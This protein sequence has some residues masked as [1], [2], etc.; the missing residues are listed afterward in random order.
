MTFILLGTGLPTAHAEGNEAFF[1]STE[2]VSHTPQE[3][4]DYIAAHPYGKVSA[5]YATEPAYSGGNYDYGS[6]TEDYLQDALN[7]LNVCRFIAGLG[8]VALD[9]QY[10]KT[11]QAGAWLCAADG[12]LAHSHSQPEGVPDD[13]YTLGNTGCGSSNIAWNYRSL[14]R[15]VVGGWVDDSDS[16]NESAVGHRRWCLSRSM[17]ATGFGQVGAY[18]AM[19]AFDGGWPDRSQEDPVVWPAPVMPE[20]LF[21]SRSMWSVQ[22]NNT[23]SDSATVTLTRLSDGE[24]WHFGNDGS[25]GT[26]YID[27]NYYGYQ[28]AILFRPDL[29]GDDYGTDCFRVQVTDGNFSLDYEVSFYDPDEVTHVHTAGRTEDTDIVPPTC[30]Q[31]GSHRR[32]TYCSDCG[33]IMSD[34]TVTDPALG[35]N[36]VDGVCTRCGRNEQALIGDADGDGEV[37]DYDAMLF[38]RYLVGWNVEI[39]LGV[40]DT[41]CDGTITDWDSMLLDRY[42]AGWNVI[43]G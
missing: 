18:M 21:D 5:S 3:I 14:S 31:A 22:R 15:A 39:D 30:R 11:A 12:V 4:E 34:E 28:P 26:F 16:R 33:E 27:N 17:Q 40:M 1:A 37:T 38:V 10:V 9:G 41:D 36:Y 8:E 43:I 2:L 19:Y 20:N 7:A 29:D 6:L 35:H 13:M 24:V 42:L 23:Y 32:I 25:D